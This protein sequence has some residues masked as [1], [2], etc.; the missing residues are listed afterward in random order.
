MAEEYASLDEMAMRVETDPSALG[1]AELLR[2]LLLEESSVGVTE[3]QVVGSPLV[4]HP[5]RA[6]RFALTN[7]EGVEFDV[8]VQARP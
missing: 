7:F 3:V 1:V 2:A 4:A 8:I 5:G 6:L